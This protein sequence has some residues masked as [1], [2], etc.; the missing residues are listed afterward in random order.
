MR[1]GLSHQWD[2][3]Q[4]IVGKIQHSQIA[5][6]VS[7]LLRN[8]GQL[9]VAQAEFPQVLQSN[10]GHCTQRDIFQTKFNQ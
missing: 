7:Q 5:H 2:I 10:L 4:I 9:I 1:Q 3:G 6:I 8:R